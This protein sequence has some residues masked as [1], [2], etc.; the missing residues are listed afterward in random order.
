MSQSIL[1]IDLI[2]VLISATGDYFMQKR[3]T[4]NIIL[5]CGCSHYSVGKSVARKV[6][7]SLQTAL[8]AHNMRAQHYSRVDFEIVILL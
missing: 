1:K 3:T 5:L 2:F 8:R 7:S 6:N 4:S